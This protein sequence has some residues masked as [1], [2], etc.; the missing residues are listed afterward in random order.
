MMSLY[1][2]PITIR[3]LA[4]VRSVTDLR[5]RNQILRAVVL[6]VKATLRWLC[7]TS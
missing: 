7:F 2:I 6:A 5:E 4:L 3:Y 1:L